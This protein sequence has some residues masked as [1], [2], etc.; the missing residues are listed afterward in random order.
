MH[1]S[2][3]IMLTL[4]YPKNVIWTSRPKIK[5]QFLNTWRAARIEVV[6]TSWNTE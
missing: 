6:V 4:L 1:I 2:E 5:I 3:L